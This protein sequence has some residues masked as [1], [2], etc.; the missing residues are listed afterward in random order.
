LKKT[1]KFPIFFEDGLNLF[2]VCVWGSDPL[3]TERLRVAGVSF[4]SL[5]ILFPENADMRGDGADIRVIPAQSLI[6]AFP[7]GS[8]RL[9]PRPLTISYG[10][11]EYMARAFLCGCADYVV[12]PWLPEELFLRC[13]RLRSFSCISFPGGSLR[14][15]AF[16]LFSE[17]KVLP[18][19]RQEHKLLEILARYANNPVNREDLLGVLGYTMG[20]VSSR[21]VDVHISSL[22]TKLK[23]CGLGKPSQRR[24]NPI[25]AVRGVGYG[26]WTML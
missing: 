1:D 4:P 10:P 26:L 9:E 2:V 24:W 25:R 18:L 22:R 20:N 13:D 15:T 14:Y 21:L 17:N 12:D 8:G 23:A 6:Q 16:A 5:M 11:V 7:F 19:S 3:I